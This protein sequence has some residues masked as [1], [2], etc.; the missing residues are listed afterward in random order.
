MADEDLG[1]EEG[2]IKNKVEKR[3]KDLSEKVKTASQERDELSKAKAEAET[4]RASAEKERDFFSSFSD[5]TGKYPGASEYKDAIKEKVLAG[6]DPEDA[7]VSVL[8]KEGKLSNYTPPARTES[9]AGGSAS[10]T[11]RNE[12]YKTVGEMTKAE[13]RAELERMEAESGGISQVLRRNM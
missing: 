2:E 8:A 1:L 11:M 7:T 10:T 5:M 13:K 3:I 12:G 4:A 9:P 6:Y